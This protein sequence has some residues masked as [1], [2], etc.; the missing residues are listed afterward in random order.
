M[1]ESQLAAEVAEPA[2]EPSPHRRA[3]RGYW[4]E[5]WHRLVRNPL[6]MASA[7]FIA[8]VAV[9]ALTAPLLSAAVTHYQYFNQDLDHTF[10]PPFTPGHLLGTNQ[11]GQDTLTRLIWGAQISLGV[12]FLTVIIS[13]VLGTAAGLA[14][15]FYGGLVDD[16]LMRL[17]D[18]LL[19]TPRLYLFILVG[20]IFY[21]QSG[22]VTLSL[23]IASVGWGSTARLVRGEVLSLAESEFMVATRSIGAGDVRLIARH[24]LPNVLPIL[25]VAASL[26][27]GGII[28]VEAGLDYLGFGIHPPTPSWGNMLS[29]AQEY[30]VHSTWLVV[31]PGAC[32]FLTVL[33]TSL[34]GNALR[35]AFDPRTR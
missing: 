11:I 26:G 16:L 9:I 25:I 35:D 4:H 22:L 30:F 7:A 1:I 21:R 32:I 12:G 18:V 20:I 6:A 29:D 15:G 2:A 23:V 27:V 33:A 28:L 13:L 10:A 34:L 24:L 19:A 3:A 31:L 14:A 5:S 8:V 17:V